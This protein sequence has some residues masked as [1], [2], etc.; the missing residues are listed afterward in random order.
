VILALLLALQDPAAPPSARAVQ[1]AELRR[2]VAKTN[3]VWKLHEW[4]HYFVVTDVGDAQFLDELERQTFET[5]ELWS[6]QFPEIESDP[7]RDDRRLVVLRAIRDEQEYYSYGGPASSNAYWSSTAGEIV[8]HD[9]P[10]RSDTLEALAGCTTFAFLDEYFGN[11]DRRGWFEIGLAEYACA[12]CRLRH[13]TGT[14]TPGQKPRLDK[15]READPALWPALDAFLLEPRSAAHRH[16]SGQADFRLVA[17]SLAR[18]LLDEELH[19]P[20]F[21]ARWAKIP[22]RYAVGWVTLKDDEKARS[23]AFEGLD[24]VALERAWHASLRP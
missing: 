12:S 5:R 2:D 24:R 18:F 15:L 16:V 11:C 9:S 1:R 4:G 21:D 14:P 10:D 13:P 23:I 17:W 7:V 3:G 19:G 22:E 8:V 20:D 6:R